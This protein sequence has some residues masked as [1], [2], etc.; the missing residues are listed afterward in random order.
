ME[1]EVKIVWI[2]LHSI[3]PS[4]DN[5][6]SRWRETGPFT[7][8]DLNLIESMKNG[9]RPYKPI[10]VVGDTIIDGNRRWNAAKEAGL[11]RVAV[12]FVETNEANIADLIA[13]EN[14]ETADF[15]GEQWNTLYVKGARLER[16]PPRFRKQIEKVIKYC[17]MDG[18][19]L[20]SAKNAAPDVIHI[21]M[22][23]VNVIK[24]IMPDKLTKDY[25]LEVL[26]WIVEND[27]RL[28]LRLWLKYGNPKRHKILIQHIEDNTHLEPLVIDN[29]QG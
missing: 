24:D 8:R 11:P 3:K 9:Y 17:G 15:R 14:G 7:D 23:A 2:D 22:R 20:L 28:P 25:P 21:V 1:K 13:Q 18:A 27:Q 10:L 29:K 4:I 5:P 6:E 16:I 12:I 19:K 26:T